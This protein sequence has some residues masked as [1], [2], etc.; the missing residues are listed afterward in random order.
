[1]FRAKNQ[2][3]LDFLGHIIRFNIWLLDGTFRGGSWQPPELLSAPN[4]AAASSF[5]ST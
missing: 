4:E 1:M 3:L 5:G 2:P